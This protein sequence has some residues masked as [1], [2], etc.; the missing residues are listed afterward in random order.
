MKP[1]DLLTG[2]HPLLS[3]RVR[4]AIMATVAAVAD[5]MDFNALRAA[6]DLTKGNLASHVR[7]LQDAGLVHVHKEIVGRKTRT[8]YTVTD[9]GRQEVRNYLEKVESLL[10]GALTG[11]GT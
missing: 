10:K 3:D 9:L 11:A 8:T 4:L 5:P 1:R 6:L 7:K 2:T